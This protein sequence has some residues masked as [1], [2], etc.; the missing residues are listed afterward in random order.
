MLVQLSSLHQESCLCLHSS[1][2]IGGY[3]STPHFPVF[4][5]S[6]LWPS[7]PAESST[8]Q[9]QALLSKAPADAALGNP[10]L[11]GIRRRGCSKS[12]GFMGVIFVFMT[13]GGMEATSLLV[14][15]RSTR[16]G[17]TQPLPTLL[18]KNPSTPGLSP[19]SS[20]AL[21]QPP[22]KENLF[23]GLPATSKPPLSSQP[24]SFQ[25]SRLLLSEPHTD[26]PSS[27]QASE[28]FP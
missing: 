28:E 6:E 26:A 5:R 16:C 4:W 14:D 11:E 12:S 3:R 1:G 2:A 21:E 9:P 10:R 7:L 8:P 25:A 18:L 22:P 27:L 24:F 20:K 17:K 15:R 19:R 13:P 23:W